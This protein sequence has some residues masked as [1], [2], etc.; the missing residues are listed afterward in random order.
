MPTTLNT[1]LVEVRRVNGAL[2][3]RTHDSVAIED[4]L[5]IQIGQDRKAYE[6]SDRSQ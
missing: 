4:P 5:E 2:A 1:S 3:V 6:P